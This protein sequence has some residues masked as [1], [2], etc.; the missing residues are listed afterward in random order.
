MLKRFFHITDKSLFY[1]SIALCCIGLISVFSAT[2]SFDNGLRMFI[3]Q[4][5]CVLIGLLLFFS[6]NFISIEAIE[7]LAKYIYILTCSILVLALIFGRGKS[8]TGTNGWIRFWGIGVQPAEIAKIGFIL[9]LSAHIKYIKSRYASINESKP[10]LMLILH[11]ALPICLI[12][13]QP[14]L[15]TA[16]V[17]IFIFAV[18][19]FLNGLSMKYILWTIGILLIVS[20]LIYF[21]LLNPAQQSRFLSFLNPNDYSRGAGYNVAQA[22]LAIGSGGIIGQGYLKGFQTGSPYLPAKHT[23]F[24]FACIAEEWGLLGCTVLISLLGFVLYKLFVSFTREEE[25]FRR[26]I[27]IGMFA[28]LFFHIFEN[29]AM[30]LGLMPVTG[31]PLPFISYGGTSMI[32]AI[33]AIALVNLARE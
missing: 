22:K 12:L 30:N 14:D 15:G 11:V 16:L 7:K 23:D 27:I 3:V 21:F 1:V 18:L 4:I 13:L 33:L 29:I 31:I 32:T 19:L 20:P 5:F 6:L 25:S 8:E 10:L 26:N 28:Y 2:S 9:S 17:F 24:I